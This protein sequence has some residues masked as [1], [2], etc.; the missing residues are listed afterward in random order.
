M[1]FRQIIVKDEQIGPVVDRRAAVRGDNAAAEP[2]ALLV[3]IGLQQHK[4]R[5]AAPCLVDKRK[6]LLFGQAPADDAEVDPRAVHGKGVVAAVDEEV[7]QLYGAPVPDARG[8]ERPVELPVARQQVVPHEDLADNRVDEGRMDPV[9]AEIA[10]PDQAVLQSGDPPV[11][12]PADSAADSSSSQMHSAAHFSDFRRLLPL[13]HAGQTSGREGDLKVVAARIGVEV[14]HLARKVEPG[15]LERLHRMG[16]HLV[17]A[18]PAGRHDGIF[19]RGV[20]DDGEGKPLER[21]DQAPLLGVGELAHVVLRVDVELLGKRHDQ[22]PRHQLAQQLGEEL[23][24]GHLGQLAVDAVEEH[25]LGQ[26]R[27]EVE[28]QLDAAPV[29]ERIDRIAAHAQRHGPLDAPLREAHL[30]E[31]LAHGFVV[32]PERR[33][34]VAQQQA[35]EVLHL[36]VRRDERRERRTHRLDCMPQIGG[37]AVAVTRRAGGRIGEAAR[38]DNHLRCLDLALEAPLVAVAHP[39]DMA[40]KGQDSSHLRIVEDFHAVLDAVVQQ[41]VGDV[42]RLAAVGEDALAP[43]DV[44]LDAPP[45]EEADG[46]PV[47]EFGKGRCEEV[48]VGAHLRGE[49]LG[50]T[51]VGDVAAPLARDADLASRLLHLLEQQHALAVACGRRGRHHAGGPRP[52]DDYVAGVLGVFIPELFHTCGK[53]TNISAEAASGGRFFHP[54]G[55][56]R[57]PHAAKKGAAP[58]GCPIERGVLFSNLDF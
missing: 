4:S 8:A 39:E 51:G 29:D 52:H 23:R 35:A 24:G 54:S 13:Q 18:H 25:L 2:A 7:L 19:K 10:R 30:A 27:L 45:L 1:L 16:V 43:L 37:K 22:R 56:R 21:L 48:G 9:A 5:A 12:A 34:H 17:A 47:V 26:R 55:R 33:P 46:R 20:V 42:P 50:R 15:D 41:R 32:D 53:D 31:L 44:E 57:R 58:H 40:R 49:L 11:D 14:E 28:H 3:G 36:V 38:G 6:H